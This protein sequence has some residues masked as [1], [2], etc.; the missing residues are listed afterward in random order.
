MPCARGSSSKPS[1]L[2]CSKAVNHR[3]LRLLQEISKHVVSLRELHAS[4]HGEILA[5]DAALTAVIAASRAA[6]RLRTIR[7]AADACN[8]DCAIAGRAV[9]ASP[10]NSLRLRYRG[11]SRAAGRS[12]QCSPAHPKRASSTRA[13]VR[14]RYP[15][16]AP[17]AIY[18]ASRRNSERCPR[19]LPARGNELR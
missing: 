13:T 10:Q 19:N 9:Q 3:S 8:R 12:Q 11:D 5:I 4:S 7:P 6:H 2:F 15:Q 14:G 16:P 17:A 1:S 18:P